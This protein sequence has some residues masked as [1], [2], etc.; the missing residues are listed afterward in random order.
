MNG[1]RGTRSEGLLTK[2]FLRLPQV[3]WA[4]LVGFV[5]R[6][7]GLLAQW[8]RPGLP[9]LWKRPTDHFDNSTARVERGPWFTIGVSWV[10]MGVS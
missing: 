7:Q 4:F 9:L 3:P 1:Q 5:A 10:N 8:W 2:D 6:A